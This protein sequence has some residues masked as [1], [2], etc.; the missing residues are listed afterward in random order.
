MA[1]PHPDDTK[2][3]IHRLLQQIRDC[4]RRGRTTE[5]AALFHCDMRIVGPD[6]RVLAA[7]RDACVKSYEDFVRD[8]TILEH[9][10]SEPE[11][12]AWG[13]TAT[14]AF[15]WKITY[16]MKGETH[17]DAGRDLFVFARHQG[18]W[19]AVWRA[20]FFTPDAGS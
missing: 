13:D 4:W 18:R 2:A 10:E 11:I 12:S 20:V 17:R 3:E 14:A 1:L 5:L 7:G 6:F 16:Q 15:G 9:E 8:A 19:Q